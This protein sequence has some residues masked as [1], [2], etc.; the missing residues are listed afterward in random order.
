MAEYRNVS[1]PTY[2]QIN[3]L[4]LRLASFQSALISNYS[5]IHL[6]KELLAQ[7]CFL[8]DP[9]RNNHKA[10]IQSIPIQP[11]QAVITALKALVAGGRSQAGG[12]ALTAFNQADL[13]CSGNAWFVGEA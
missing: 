11:F 10:L 6:A 5:A 1:L 7:H 2:Y 4:I 13:A 3:F 8:P 9:S 12:R